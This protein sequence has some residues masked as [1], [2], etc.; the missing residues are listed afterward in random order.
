MVEKAFMHPAKETV[1]FFGDELG[2]RRTLLKSLDPDPMGVMAVDP[3]F[4]SSIDDMSY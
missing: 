3:E 2:Q 1:S 4:M